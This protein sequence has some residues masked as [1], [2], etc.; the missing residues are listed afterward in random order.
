MGITISLKPDS[1][2]APAIERIRFFVVFFYEDNLV[3]R[4]FNIE[5]QEGDI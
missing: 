5:F 3:V 2:Q 1:I 4:S